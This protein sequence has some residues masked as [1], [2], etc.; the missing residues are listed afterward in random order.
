MPEK[1]VVGIMCL[2]L[3]IA[4]AI[5]LAVASD[6]DW[7]FSRSETLAYACGGGDLEVITDTL[8][9]TYVGYSVDEIIAS[10]QSRTSALG[11]NRLILMSFRL[12]ERPTSGYKK[13]T[14]MNSWTSVSLPIAFNGELGINNRLDTYLDPRIESNLENIVYV[15]NERYTFGSKATFPLDGDT[16]NSP[17]DTTLDSRSSELDG[18]GVSFGTSVSNNLNAQG[19]DYTGSTTYETRMGGGD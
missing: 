5:P 2:T 15:G 19:L 7:V 6:E 10:T 9:K 14:T 13:T 17:P 8:S 3:V 16:K 1:I 4:M 18:L 12:V 11:V